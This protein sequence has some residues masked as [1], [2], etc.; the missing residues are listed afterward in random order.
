[1]RDTQKYSEIHALNSDKAIW[2]TTQEHK[3]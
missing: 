1:M 2:C 3:S